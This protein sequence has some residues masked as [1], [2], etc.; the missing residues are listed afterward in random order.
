MVFV[1]VFRLLVAVCGAL[2]GLAAGNHYAATAV[3]RSTGAAIGVL[4]GYVV[5]GVVGRLTPE[6][7][8]RRPDRF[9]TF[10]PPSCSQGCCSAAWAC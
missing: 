8:V 6:E 1:E 5:G 4:V 10:L 9:V 2:V 3:G 7:C